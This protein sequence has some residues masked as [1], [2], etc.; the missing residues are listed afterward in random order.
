MECL[1]DLSLGVLG[2]TLGKDKECPPIA[3]STTIDHTA[4]SVDVP[5]MSFDVPRQ[6]LVHLGPAVRWE[7]DPSSSESVSWEI[8]PGVPLCAALP[9]SALR[10]CVQTLCRMDV[11]PDFVVDFHLPSP[12]ARS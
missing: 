7:Q 2:Q 3:S 1:D 5:E 11:K 4:S 6:T 8:P 9:T 12:V 10:H